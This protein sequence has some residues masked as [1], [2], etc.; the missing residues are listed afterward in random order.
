[1]DVCVLAVFMVRGGRLPGKRA[2]KESRALAKRIAR[3]CE[4]FVNPA[5]VVE[6]S[7][8]APFARVARVVDYSPAYTDDRAGERADEREHSLLTRAEVVA[9]L[10]SLPV[11]A[12]GV[13]ID[14]ACV[15]A[16]IRRGRV[17]E[18]IVARFDGTWCVC[19]R[20]ERA[21]LLPTP[22]LRAE[23]LIFESA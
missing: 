19:T 3:E 9:F 11:G 2:F 4:S 17:Y 22:R 6:S 16:F 23:L 5:A 8:L 20:S 13:W 12:V 18:R 1:M 15:E 21:H 14:A 10:E 7:E